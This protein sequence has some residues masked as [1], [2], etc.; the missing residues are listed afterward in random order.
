VSIQPWQL[1]EYSL[2]STLV[3]IIVLAK[4][5]WIK[6]VG[7]L[8]CFILFFANPF[9]FTEEGVSKLERGVKRFDVPEKVVVPVESYT[10]RAKRES[11]QL[12]QHNKDLINE[13]LN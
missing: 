6:Y 2:W 13:A 1:L 8:L 7:L 3:L 5:N 10:D 9:K 12:K 4:Y 11:Q